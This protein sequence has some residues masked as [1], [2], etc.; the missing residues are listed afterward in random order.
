MSELTAELSKPG[1]LWAIELNCKVPRKM[2][3]ANERVWTFRRRI[4][5]IAFA[6]RKGIRLET[7]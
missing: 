4:D 6:R 2:V 5:A 1:I 3:W 7:T